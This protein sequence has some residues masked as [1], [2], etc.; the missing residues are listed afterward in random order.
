MGGVD[1]DGDEEEA[2]QLSEARRVRRLVDEGGAARDVHRHQKLL[3]RLRAAAAARTDHRQ[4]AA[5]KDRFQRCM[6]VIR[7]DCYGEYCLCHHPPDRLHSV[8]G[9]AQKHGEWFPRV[10]ISWCAV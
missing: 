4:L 6:L 8:P 7:S 1:T 3:A 10:R 5:I 9:T 2:R